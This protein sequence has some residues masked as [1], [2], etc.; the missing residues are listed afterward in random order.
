M[1]IGL[2]YSAASVAVSRD[3]NAKEV[4]AGRVQI[5]QGSVAALPFPDRTFD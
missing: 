3:T 5:E 2:D 1:V 4:D